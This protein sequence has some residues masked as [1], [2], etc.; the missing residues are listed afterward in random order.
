MTK[1]LPNIITTVR[2][3]LTIPI[4][5]LLLDGNFRDAL[6]LFLIAA[7]TDGLDGFLARRFHCVSAYGAVLDPI[8]DKALVTFSLGALTL[9][10]YF[11]LW[12][13]VLVMLRDICIGTFAWL[14]TKRL[15]WKKL[16][17]R[18]LSKVNTMIQLILIVLLLF[19]LGVFNVNPLILKGLMLALLLSTILSFADYIWQWSKLWW[20]SS[21]M[22][23]L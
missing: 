8:A 13:F 5:V 1:F 3:I 4:F 2:L 23:K 9:L 18:V 12:M 15:Q 20:S 6:Y 16:L 22:V 10:N 19:H 21:A 14:L 7:L 17:P 11:P